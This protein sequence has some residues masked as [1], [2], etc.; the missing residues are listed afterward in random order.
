MLLVTP[1]LC[2]TRDQDWKRDPTCDIWM[3]IF[4]NNLPVCIFSSF[5]YRG[6]GFPTVSAVLHTQILRSLSYSGGCSQLPAVTV[7]LHFSASSCSALLRWL[8][9]LC[10]SSDEKTGACDSQQAGSW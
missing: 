8:H 10:S 4:T 5:P 9:M 7:V 3:H 6:R 2:R 1:P